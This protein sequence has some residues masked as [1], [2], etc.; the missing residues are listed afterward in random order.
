MAHTDDISHQR[1]IPRNFV[2]MFVVVLSGIYA[3][4]S[5]DPIATH[6]IGPELNG[7]PTQIPEDPIFQRTRSV[8]QTIVISKPGIYDYDNV[9]HVWEGSGSCNQTENQPHILRIAA[10]NV[11]VRNFAYKNAPDGVHIATCSKGQG[12]DCTGSIS[13]ILLENVTG[14]ACEDALTTGI[15]TSNITLNR[16]YFI[17]NPNKKHRDKLL[18]INFGNNLRIYNTIFKNS[19]RPVRFKSGSAIT[20]AYNRFYGFHHAI[21]GDTYED[22]IGIVPNRPAV[23]N[24]MGNHFQD[25]TAAFSMM[26]E[27]TVTSIGDAFLN[28]RSRKNVKDGAKV[29]I[30]K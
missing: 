21:R 20:L 18:Q 2:A 9:L 5:A 19:T 12:N 26:G 28:V 30:K 8:T 15:G 27:I 29:T 17:G 4:S 23:V 7:D 6:D 10:S 3:L 25:G 1:R 11:T 24:T 14:W 22:I 16:C 13:N